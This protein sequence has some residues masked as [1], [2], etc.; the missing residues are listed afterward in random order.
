MLLLLLVA[1]G[2][3]RFLAQATPVSQPTV[4]PT[5]QPAPTSVATLTWED[6]ASSVLGIATNTATTAPND[7][8]GTSGITSSIW[9]RL[10]A[11]KPGPWGSKRLYALLAILYV[12]LLGILVKSTVELLR[13][14]SNP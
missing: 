6:W 9:E 8:I 7:S 10:T 1:V 3:I 2:S 13:D 12:V 4:T 5:P 11:E 14:R